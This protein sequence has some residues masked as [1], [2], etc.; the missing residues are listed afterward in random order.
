M[1]G[2]AVGILGQ[3]PLTT[4]KNRFIL[5][6]TDLFIKWTEA[7]PL[8]HQET[9]IVAKAIVDNF[10]SEFGT[11]IQLYSDK[12]RNF[13]S[14]LFKDMC[15]HLGIASVHKATSRTPTVMVLGREVTLPL[16]AVIGQSINEDDEVPD[17]D[18]YVD[19]LKQKFV[20]T[21]KIARKSLK[22]SATYLKRHHD[23]KAKKRAFRRGQ[24][25]WIHDLIRKVSVCTKL[26][27]P[28][29]C[30]F[31]VEKRIDDVKYRVK[32]FAGQPSSL[33]S[34]RDVVPPERISLPL[35]YQGLPIQ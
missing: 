3:L 8:P 2:L 6:I 20:E 21:H 25:V 30:S 13:D 22:Q 11:S 7:V 26:K 4:N 32:R 23:L 24:P 33:V 1:G 15:N 35:V 14:D 19:N 17:P 16:Q 18:N 10:V 28:W 12:G 5:V 29:K 34:F 31:I 27:S 9:T